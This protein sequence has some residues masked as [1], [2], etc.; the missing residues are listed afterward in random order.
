MV[1]APLVVPLVLTAVGLFFTYARLD[2]NGTLPG[3]ILAFAVTAFAGAMMV[4]N[5]SY[6]SFKQIDINRPMRFVWMVVMAL[7]FV[8]IASDP[9]RALLACFGCYA[10]WAPV[11]WV[12]RRLR[13]KPLEP[14][15]AGP[16]NAGPG[17]DA[18]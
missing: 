1:M 4:S 18:P 8:V 11:M 5:L 3:L 10:L 6:P 2:L 12:V 14:P 9:P 13:R 17:G 7:V 15:A 16:G